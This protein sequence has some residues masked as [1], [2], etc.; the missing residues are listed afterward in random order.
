MKNSPQ[1]VTKRTLTTPAHAALLARK[2]IRALESILDDYE[3][4]RKPFSEVR[5]PQASVVIAA[6]AKLIDVADNSFTIAANVNPNLT[7][8]VSA[9][10]SDEELEAIIQNGETNGPRS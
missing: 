5:A 7:A 6:A 10:L 3:E 9:S 2:G 8:E 4:S 1:T